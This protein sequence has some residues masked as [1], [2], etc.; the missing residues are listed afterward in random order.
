MSNK[1]ERAAWCNM[2]LRC[3]NPQNEKY[4]TYGGVGITVCA[5]WLDSFDAFLADVGQRPSTRHSL[6]RYPNAAGNYEPGNCRWATSAEQGSN[7]RKSIHLADGRV[8][9][10]SQLAREANISQGTLHGRIK[11]GMSLSDALTVPVKSHH[12]SKRPRAYLR[13]GKPSVRSLAK[14]AGV[15]KECV[16]SR[17]RKGIRLEDALARA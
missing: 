13:N 15:D 12:P 8:V 16:Y 14:Q 10:L 3:H 6:D 17:L 2:K 1:A 9:S 4:A 5:R 7:T 11:R